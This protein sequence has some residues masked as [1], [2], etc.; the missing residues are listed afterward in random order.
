MLL[1]RALR[2]Q[3]EDGNMA[4]ERNQRPIFEGERNADRRQGDRRKSP[5][6]KSDRVWSFIKALLIVILTVAV[7]RIFKL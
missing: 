7:M 6:R 2:A 4:H 5:R 1:D 3:M